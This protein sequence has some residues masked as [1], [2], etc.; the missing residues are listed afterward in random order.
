MLNYNYDFLSLFRII[1]FILE[2]KA[3][4]C[5]KQSLSMYVYGDLIVAYDLMSE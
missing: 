1:Y 4:F 2:L 3:Y 5:V